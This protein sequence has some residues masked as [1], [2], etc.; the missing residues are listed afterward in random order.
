V[1]PTPAHDQF[2]IKADATTPLD[3]I[4]E[5]TLSTSAVTLVPF[6]RSGTTHDFQLQLATPTTTST[7]AT[8][9]IT[10]TIT[11]SQY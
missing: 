8:Q 5:L 10:V 6:L 1:Q 9:S 7:G 2:T 3:A 11:A 4:Y